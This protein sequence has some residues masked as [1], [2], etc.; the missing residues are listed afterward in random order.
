M[1]A[2]GY[3]DG[4]M[5]NESSLLS[6][7]RLFDF[8]EPLAS[9]ISGIGALVSALC[10]LVLLL[11]TRKQLRA[12]LA[13]VD[14]ASQQAATAEAQAAAARAS[15]EYSRNNLR[16]AEL[17]RYDTQAP[18]LATVVN[19]SATRIGFTKVSLEDLRGEIVPEESIPDRFTFGAPAEGHG[20]WEAWVSGEVVVIN[21][22]SCSVLAT[23]AGASGEWELPDGRGE[24]YDGDHL[25]LRPRDEVILK[26]T[27]SYQLHDWYLDRRKKS[28]DKLGVFGGF[29]VNFV[30][31]ANPELVDNH[32]FNYDWH[33][34]SPYC[35]VDE[36]PRRNI[37]VIEGEYVYFDDSPPLVEF[38]NR[39][40]IYPV[41]PADEENAN[42][43]LFPKNY[44]AV[45]PSLGKSG[46]L[47]Q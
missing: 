9:T 44:R 25:L 21:E 37:Q 10:A 7:R 26:W 28:T 6:I 42:P 5:G 36:S 24:V 30:S 16:S 18:N 1:Q 32:Q 33:P 22:G 19:S 3:V 47:N 43:G 8:I 13:Q 29:T 11:I 23:V 45:F 46:F 41:S 14:V 31:A 40:R 17:T 20:L 27:K 39:E 12:A 15:V 38:L 34:L 2:N 4:V 35:R